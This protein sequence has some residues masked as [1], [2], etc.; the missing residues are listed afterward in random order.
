MRA[1][2]TL[3][4]DSKLGVLISKG[5]KKTTARGGELTCMKVLIRFNYVVCKQV[6][7]IVVLGQWT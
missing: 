3:S 7:G 4:P 6:N 1:T 2:S 5:P